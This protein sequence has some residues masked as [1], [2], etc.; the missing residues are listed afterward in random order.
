MERVFCITA[1][2]IVSAV[3]VLKYRMMS[4]GKKKSLIWNQSERIQ[5]LLFAVC[6]ACGQK[7]SQSEA[8]MRTYSIRSVIS[9]GRY[10]LVYIGLSVKAHIGA[11]LVCSM[12]QTSEV[13][14][15][16]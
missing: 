8:N 1:S 7:I 10:L 6:S 9:I 2:S 12:D 13:M 15:I 16:R 11:S 14:I 5:S 3:I 4:R